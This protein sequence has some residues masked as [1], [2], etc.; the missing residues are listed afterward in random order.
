MVLLLSVGVLASGVLLCVIWQERQRTPLQTVELHFGA[1]VTTSAVE[2][3]LAGIAGLPARGLVLFEVL[4]D[5]N[6]IRH[7]LRAPQPTLDTLRG[8]WRGVLP[9]LRLDKPSPPPPEDWTHSVALRLSGRYPVLR[10]DGVGESAAAL[11]GALQP[12]AAGERLLVRWSLAPGRRPMLAYPAARGN[13]GSAQSDRLGAFLG[14][15]APSPEHLRVLRAKYAGPVLEGRGAISVT[16]GHTKRASHLIS[17]VVSVMRSRGS[18]YGRITARRD[19][20]GRLLNNWPGT[21]SR[22]RFAPSE[23]TCLLGFPLGAPQVPGLTLGTSPVLLPSRR[24]PSTGRVLMA[25]NWPGIDRALAQPVIGGLSHTLVCGPTG[26]GKSALIANLIVADLRAGRGFLLLDGKGD[27]AED[28]L[29]RIPDNRVDD[30]IVLDPGRDGPLPGLRL[31]GR[32]SDPELTADL[33]LGIFADLFA[34]SWGPLSSKWLRAGLVLLGH[35]RQATLAD[36]PFVY[37]HDAYR[38]RLLARV[39][40]PLAR[41]TWATFEAMGPAE[42]VHQLAAPLNK[43]EQVIGRRVV[44]GVLAQTE[45]KLDMH[46]ALRRGRVVIVTL[47]VGKIGSPAARLIGALTIHQLF[48]AVQARASLAPRARRPFFAYVDE[49]KVLGD[50]PVPLDSLYELAR[51]LG[52]GILLSAQS[53]VQL[54]AGLRSA[55]TTNASTLVAF[56]QSAED[57]HLLARELPGVSGEGL[58]HLGPFEVIAR[59]GLGPGDVTA[60]VSGRTFPLPPTTSD[61]EAIRRASADRYGVDPASVDAALAERHG[62][63]DK[64][65]PSAGPGEDKQFGIGRVRRPS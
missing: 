25:S 62:P 32:G 19:G 40:D 13:R 55:A 6:G 56:R 34:D 29:A 50:I 31:F 15:S 35:D 5:E 59:I 14:T 26:V 23:L 2:A 49:P 38:R 8:Q 33:V 57:A 4:A 30:V 7:F 65:T 45:P 64:S 28:V 20:P 42:R 36:L 3:M 24:I 11:L 39:S 51:G 46:E 12:L 1:D 22:D 16:A 63:G 41:A 27:L 60:P 10:S 54:P 43:I 37:S 17:R 47:A 21:A 48:L 9:S 44:R 61:P 53:P 52:V 58:Q 18:V